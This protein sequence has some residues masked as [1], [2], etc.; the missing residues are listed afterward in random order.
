MPGSY[1]GDI[2]IGRYGKNNRMDQDDESDDYPDLQSAGSIPVHVFNP[3]GQYVIIWFCANK[4]MDAGGNCSGICTSVVPA[5]S[6]TGTWNT[7]QYGPLKLIQTGDSVSG[8]YMSG[9]IPGTVSGT[10]SNGGFVLTGSWHEGSSPGMFEFDL[11]N[12]QNQF[13]GWWASGSQP[14]DK[15]KNHWDNSR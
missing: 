11:A 13:T 9:T 4:G 7:V 3:Y 8:T 1:R 2:E 14:I 12:N 10:V 15:T 5:V 6:W